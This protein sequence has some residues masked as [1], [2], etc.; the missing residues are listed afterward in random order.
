MATEVVFD[1]KK[2][3]LESHPDFDEDK[4]TQIAEFVAPRADQ[5]YFLDEIERWIEMYL[6]SEQPQ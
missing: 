1:I 6:A 2:I 5:T 3:V 4:A